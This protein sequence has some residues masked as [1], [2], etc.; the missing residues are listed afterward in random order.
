[1]RKINFI[2]KYFGWLSIIAGTC[3]IITGRPERTIKASVHFHN[4]ANVE[5]KEKGDDTR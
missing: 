2:N 1:M 5:F 4:G 3:S